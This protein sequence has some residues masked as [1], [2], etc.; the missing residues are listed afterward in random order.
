LRKTLIVGQVA[1]TLVLLVAAGLFVQTLAR[2]E[3]KGP[4]F[5]TTN[6]MTFE[7][8]PR[9][10]GYDSE[11]SRR[12][13]SEVLASLRAQP[14]VADAAVAAIDLLH[15]G[16]WSDDM[17]IAADTRLT[18]DRNVHLN[19]VTP[20]FFDMMGVPIVVGRG[21]DERDAYRP[22]ESGPFRSIIVNE[23]F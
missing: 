11:A 9:Q 7:I 5:R 14:G 20:N 2:L 23:T 21:F 6:V 19:P 1:F 15:G 18:T 13:V 8:D 17:T 10:S 3:D 16:S 22:G 12:I 4:G